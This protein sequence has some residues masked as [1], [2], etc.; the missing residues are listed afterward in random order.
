MSHAFL[1][2]FQAAPRCASP[3]QCAAS[4]GP[5]VE[6]ALLEVAGRGPEPLRPWDR[7]E[8]LGVCNEC[9]EESRRR[10]ER[11]REEVWEH[12]P[13][14]F[15]MGSWRVLRETQERQDRK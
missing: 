8:R 4:R 6:W 15:D 13:E 2:A 5:L 10:H 9:V 11:G 12:L 14:F 3:T 7:W 1:V